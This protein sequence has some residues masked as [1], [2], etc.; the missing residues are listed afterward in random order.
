MLRPRL[1]AL[2]LQ[3]RSTKFDLIPFRK[4]WRMTDEEGQRA[5]LLKSAFPLND[6]GEPL[7][8]HLELRLAQHMSSFLRLQYGLQLERIVMEQP[9]NVEFGE[10]ALPLAFE[11]AKKLRKAPRKI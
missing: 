2:G 1:S 5:A 4:G 6:L 11:L 7:Y 9:P 10:F 3:R 8:G